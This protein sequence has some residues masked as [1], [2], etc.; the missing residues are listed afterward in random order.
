MPNTARTVADI[1]ALAEWPGEQLQLVVEKRL[2][3]EMMIELMR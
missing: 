3:V 2:G 1:L